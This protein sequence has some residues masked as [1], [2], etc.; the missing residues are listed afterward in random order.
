M[1]VYVPMIERGL[2]EG[3][4][5]G[6]KKGREEGLEKGLEKGLK[7]GHKEVALNM[8]KMGIDLQLILSSTKLNQ[9]EIEELK[10]TN[11]I[12]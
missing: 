7:E 2:Q 9:Q 11:K 4:Q 12:T 10:K 8:L 3:L 1:G 6:L 5:K